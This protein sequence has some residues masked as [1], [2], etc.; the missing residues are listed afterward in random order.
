[1][2]F[3]NKSDYPNNF[4]IL[5]SQNPTQTQLYSNLIEASASAYFESDPFSRYFLKKKFY[6]AESL[7]AKK[8]FGKTLDAGTGIGFFIPYLSIISKD[9]VGVDRTGAVL[10]AREMIKKRHILNATVD[11][12]DLMSLPYPDSTFDCVV[13]LS[14]LDNFTEI[15]LKIVLSLFKRIL[16]PG[17]FLVVG[18][19]TEN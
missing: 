10:Y 17:G 5:D 16:K 14:T 6:H 12:Y 7:L 1:M 18:Y 2:I 11:Q 9:V 13:S 15:Q 4:G 3:P 8:N 19:S